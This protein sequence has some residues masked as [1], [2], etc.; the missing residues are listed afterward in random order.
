MD[1]MLPCIRTAMK[2]C[3]FSSNAILT[4]LQFTATNFSKNM[5]LLKFLL[6]DKE[7]QIYENEGKKSTI[8]ILSLSKRVTLL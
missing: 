4:F 3:S 8:S 5:N 2:V 1:L 6:T 7:L